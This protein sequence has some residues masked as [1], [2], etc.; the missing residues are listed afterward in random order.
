M[1]PFCKDAG[2]RK[3]QRDI[4]EKCTCRKFVH[5][6]DYDELQKKV[7]RLEAELENR[8]FEPDMLASDAYHH[9][10]DIIE[11]YVGDRCGPDTLSNSVCDSLRFLL[12]EWRNQKGGHHAGR[13]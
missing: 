10:T 11:P 13:K 8:S 6:S 1:E 9:C 5:E 4:G 7:A 2:H 3:W 12:G